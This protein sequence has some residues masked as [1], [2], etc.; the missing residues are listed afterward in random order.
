MV[1]MEAILTA[2]TVHCVGGV[3]QRMKP[4]PIFFVRMKLWHAYLG[5][6]FLEPEDIKSISL[7]AIWNLVKHQG[8]H[9]LIMGHKGPI[10]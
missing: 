9:K 3:K 2:Q 8:P 1:A 10:N 6:C 5:C 7:G 4:Q